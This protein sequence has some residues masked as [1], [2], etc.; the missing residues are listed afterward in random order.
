MF[1]FAST[2]FDLIPFR[3]H[4]QCEDINNL[5]SF[6]NNDSFA[7]VEKNTFNHETIKIATYLLLTYVCLHWKSSYFPRRREA[8]AH[9][10]HEEMFH[11]CTHTHE[12]QPIFIVVDCSIECLTDVQMKLCLNVVLRTD[13]VRCLYLREYRA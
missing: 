7:H 1:T 4:A 2:I 13:A 8:S 12:Q 9:L 11:T 5:F 3:S 6:S 10:F